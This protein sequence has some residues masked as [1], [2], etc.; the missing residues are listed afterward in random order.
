[1]LL[2]RP[3]QPNVDNYIIKQIKHA[4]EKGES[5]VMVKVP[6]DQKIIRPK[7]Q[8]LIGL[9]P[10]TWQY[11]YK[12]LCILMVSSVQGCILCLSQIKQ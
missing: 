1:M 10:M 7:L 3:L 11:G 2:I 4:D 8:L 6:V 12:T 5:E 9:I